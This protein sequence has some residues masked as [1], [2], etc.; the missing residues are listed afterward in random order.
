MPMQDKLLYILD[1]FL[2]E[3]YEF[4]FAFF[5]QLKLSEWKESVDD[6]EKW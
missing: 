1:I 5:R 4:Y 2:M 3:E 6:A